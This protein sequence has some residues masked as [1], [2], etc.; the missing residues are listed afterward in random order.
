VRDEEK[1]F[2]MGLETH[3]RDWHKIFKLLGTRDSKNV[4]SHAQRHFV[5]LCYNNKELPAEVQEFGKGHT[6][7]GKL[8]DP[9]SGYECFLKNEPRRESN[10]FT[11]SRITKSPKVIERKTPKVRTCRK[12]RSVKR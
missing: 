4:R 3:G 1:S 9:E 11:T 7:S 5:R 10:F 2:L 12:R 8:L 6:L